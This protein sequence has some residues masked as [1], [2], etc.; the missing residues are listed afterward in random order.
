MSK[1]S[2]LL[3]ACLVSLLLFSS[4]SKSSGPDAN[5]AIGSVGNFNVQ[6]SPRQPDQVTINWATPTVP[7]GSVLHY[8]IYLSNNLLQD[9]LSVTNFTM[10]NL[11]GSQSYSGKV[12][13]YISSTDSATSNFIIPAYTPGP[14]DSTFVLSKVTDAGGLTLRFEYDNSN[15]RLRSWAKTYT[16]YYDSTIVYYDAAGK[17]L[18]TVRR[19]S[20]I[21][22][23]FT[24]IPNIF[25]YDGQGRVVK[26]YHKTNYSTN[27]S[28]SYLTSLSMPLDFVYEIVS[29]DSLTYDGLNRVNA[30]YNFN[31]NN[32]T[33]AP[34]TEGVYTSYKLISYS[35]LND[36]LVSKIETYT[37]NAAGT[38]DL[39]ETV[40]FN[41]YNDKV[42]PYYSLFKKFYQVGVDN[43]WTYPTSIPYY[44]FPYA[45]NDYLTASPYLCTSIN[46]A[47]LSY[48]YNS[49]SLVTACIRGAASFEWVHFEYQKV[50]R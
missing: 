19:N 1:L 22:S 50:P 15:K 30:V 7:S 3:I 48:T 42:N 49:D 37:A 45:Y 27:L 44:F 36:S 5:T 39:T 17:V 34:L 33:G 10:T 35:A 11:T 43:F 16:T 38:F 13:A 12:V 4:C 18:S 2:V 41:S 9:N 28:Y 46:S 29:Y 6:V 8:K 25:I 40:S 20:T 24:V 23:P 21:S 31:Y 14:N 32:A 47:D 26:V